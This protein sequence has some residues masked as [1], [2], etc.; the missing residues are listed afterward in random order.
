MTVF[1][2][3][4]SGV[5]CVLVAIISLTTVLP[6]FSSDYYTQN[7][8]PAYHSTTLQENAPVQTAAAAFPNNLRFQLEEIPSIATYKVAFAGT[9]G[10]KAGHEGM[11]FVHNNPAVAHVKVIA[12]AKGTV[13]Y[14]RTGCPQSAMFGKNASL[15]EAGS[16]WGNHVVLYHGNGIYTRYAH[17]APG[18]IKAKVGDKMV[19]GDVIGEMG[20]SGRS[21]T[22][23]LHFELGYKSSYFI[24]SKPAQ[25]FDLVLNPEKFFPGTKPPQPAAPAVTPS[26]FISDKNNVRSGPSTSEKVIAI[27]LKGDKFKLIERKGEWLKVHLSGTKFEE[28]KIIGWT[29]Q[30]N[31]R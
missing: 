5:L 30:S 4:A 13:A 18:S 23:H 16:G 22:R 10:K 28:E 27:P 15:R 8:A 31:V 24:A 6:A 14:V 11:D 20:N 25:S 21:E 2:F 3:R 1:R 7:P 29:H 26:T 17:L 9:A 12:A 19:A